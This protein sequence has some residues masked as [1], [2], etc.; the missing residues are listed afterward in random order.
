VSSQYHLIRKVTKRSGNFARFHQPL[1]WRRLMNSTIKR[2]TLAI[3]TS[4]IVIFT[5]HASAAEPVKFQADTLTTVAT[6][7]GLPLGMGEALDPEASALD[8]T[9]EGLSTAYTWVKVGGVFVMKRIVGSTVMKITSR[10]TCGTWTTV[11]VAQ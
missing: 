6:A 10:I 4:V 11:C 9:G 3:T 7:A 2:A 1:V 8:A 5:T